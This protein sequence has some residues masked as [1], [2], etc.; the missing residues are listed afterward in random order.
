MRKFISFFHV[1]F[2]LPNFVSA[3]V[4]EIYSLNHIDDR[5]GYC[6]D[7][8]GHKFKA[9]VQKGLQ[10]HTCYSYQGEITVDQGFDSHKLIDNQF[11]ISYFNVCIEIKLLNASTSLQLKKCQNDQLQKF[12]RDNEGRIQ[13]VSGMNLCLTIAKG[14]PKRGGG[15]SPVHL[16][17]KLSLKDC[18]VTL[19]S[20]QRW[21]KRNIRAP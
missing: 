4:V 6:I 9:K 16:I 21:G 12:K 3:E 15:G 19:K 11:N 18:S 1:L 2:L 20:F 8:K 5:R 13:P 10:A 7:I 17:R 14:Q